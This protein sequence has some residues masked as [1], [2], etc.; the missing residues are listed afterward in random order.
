M[1]WCRAALYPPPAND[2]S[3]CQAHIYKKQ[4]QMRLF[5]YLISCIQTFTPAIAMAKVNQ[6]MHMTRG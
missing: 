6:K 2:I 4:P 5:S 1:I 3:F